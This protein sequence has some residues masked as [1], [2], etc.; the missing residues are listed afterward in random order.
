MPIYMILYLSILIFFITSHPNF[1]LTQ[2][3]IIADR[4][5]IYTR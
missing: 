4:T 5:D 3:T 2:K 1:Q